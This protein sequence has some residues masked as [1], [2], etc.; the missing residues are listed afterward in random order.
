MKDYDDY[1]SGKGGSFTLYAGSD[2][3]YPY[4]LEELKKE[5]A[6]I[7]LES[8]GDI[9]INGRVAANDM[10]VVEGMREFLKK[11]NKNSIQANPRNQENETK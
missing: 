7:R 5:P 8:N 2:A 3:Y 4:T 11:V 6:S 1:V 10:E 9:L